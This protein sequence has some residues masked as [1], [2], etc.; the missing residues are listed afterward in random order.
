MK[1]IFTSLIFLA[2]CT[3]T[4]LSQLVISEISYNP[5]ESNAD[6]LEYIEL[7]N[8]G[9][10]T[11]NLTKYKFSAGIDFTFPNM[12]LDAGKYML[13]TVNDTA[14]F[15]VYGI[16]TLQWKTGALSNSGEAISIVDSLNNPIFS[17]T[18]AKVAPWPT[19]AEGTDGG[20]KSIELCMPTYSRPY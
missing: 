2:L 19:F 8:A 10:T 3:T 12:T 11:L 18:Y 13:L 15:R 5:P 4:G 17:V 1:N 16:N 9:T 20:G 14:F 7:Y 6:S